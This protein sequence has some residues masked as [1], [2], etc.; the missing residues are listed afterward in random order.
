MKPVS[1]RFTPQEAAV[2]LSFEQRQQHAAL[3]AAAPAV[4]Y[5]QYAASTAAPTSGRVTSTI[6]QVAQP[7]YTQTVPLMY[8]IATSGTASLPA[9]ATVQYMR[10][11]AAAQQQAQLAAFSSY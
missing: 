8:S 6:C 11:A 2:H 7:N 3:L 9:A 10:A 5:A 4:A 1:P